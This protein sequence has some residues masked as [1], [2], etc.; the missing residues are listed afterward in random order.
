MVTGILIHSGK[1]NVKTK[2]MK[3]ASWNVRTLLDLR[4][5]DRPERR[6]ALVAAELERYCIDIAG[7]QETRFTSSGQLRERSHTFFWSGRN[8]GERREAGVA[9]AISNNLVGSLTASPVSVSDRI[10]TLRTALDD[11]KFVTFI[12]AY[13][14]HSLQRRADQR[15]VLQLT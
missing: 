13:A 5:N 8:E 11:H 2:K 9:L 3:L 7:L 12:V 6:T 10:I 15:S 1:R 4:S 14:P